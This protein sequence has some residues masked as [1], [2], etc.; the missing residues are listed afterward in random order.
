MRACYQSYKYSSQSTFT[1]KT[2]VSIRSKSS[3]NDYLSW[4]DKALT[5]KVTGVVGR[6]WF[7]GKASVLLSEG[8]W[9]DYPRC[10]SVLGQDTEPQT[11]LDVL[12]G[13]LHGSQR[14]QCLYV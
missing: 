3:Q 13:I 10:Q 5:E 1:F 8:C 2:N 6:L 12:V 7:R 14:H 11:A 4:H 9:F